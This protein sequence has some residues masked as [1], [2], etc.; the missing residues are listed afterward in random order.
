MFEFLFGGTKSK[1]KSKTKTLKSKINNK[2]KHQS[3]YKNVMK[4]HSYLTVKR[5]RA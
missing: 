3:F 4:K 2:K 5:I 1:S